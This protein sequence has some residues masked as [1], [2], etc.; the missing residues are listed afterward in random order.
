MHQN[1]VQ[2]IHEENVSQRERMKKGKK[3]KITQET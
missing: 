3:K 2:N 1:Q